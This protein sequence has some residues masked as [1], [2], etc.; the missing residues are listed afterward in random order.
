M[1]GGRGERAAWAWVTGARGRVRVERGQTRD[2][3]IDVVE[4]LA[5]VSA[6]RQILAVVGSVWN[7][8]H[9]FGSR[10]L[11][12]KRQAEKYY[13]LILKNIVR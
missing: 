4:H 8:P 5:G 3:L 6:Q 10:Y 9:M 13:S 1:A 11:Y 2:A 7:I 12:L